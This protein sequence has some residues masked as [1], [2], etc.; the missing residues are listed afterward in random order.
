MD[1]LR[2]DLPVLLLHNMNPEWEPED[3]REAEQE[4]LTLGNALKDLGHPI[5]VV[6]VEDGFLADRL[7]TFDPRDYIVFNWCEEL[8][9]IP[10]SEPEVVRVMEQL[11]FV[12]TGLS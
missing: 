3:R 11:G 6:A 4:V 2:Y 9:G 1:E 10:R 12:F 7:S 5:E 8:P